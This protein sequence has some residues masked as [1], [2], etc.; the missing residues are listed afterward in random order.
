MPRPPEV[1]GSSA[2][3][4]VAWKPGRDR[5]LCLAGGAAL[6]V[7]AGAVYGFGAIAESMRDHLL[8]SS[9]QQ[10]ALALCGNVG[11]WVGSFTGG[12]VADTKGP[13]TAMLGGALFFGV[14][15]GG[16]WLVLRSGATTASGGDNVAY[17]AAVL[18]LV[19]GLGS[20]WV[21]NATIFTNSANFG[22]AA[23]AK[24]IGL[25]ATLFGAS[26]TI[27]STVLNGCVGGKPQ[28][29]AA[30]PSAALSLQA[31]ALYATDED[32]ELLSAADGS[33]AG[34]PGAGYTCLGG[35][36][37]GGIVSYFF[38]LAVAL[39]L[40]TTVGAFASFRITNG[41]ERAEAD[42]SEGEEPV[43][44]RLNISSGGVLVLL[45]FVGVTS[46]LVVGK[47]G[48]EVAVYIRKYTS[49]PHHTR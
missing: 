9:H 11:L 38:L 28:H 29:A 3:S 43:S 18:W 8:L 25:L 1:L 48:Q 7:C 39:P 20:G 24:V 49:N 6:I 37:N 10:G 13:R 19:S 14:G 12:I 26:S 27:W 23:R 2:P 30:A 22:P 40:I 47:D 46:G 5:W 15:Y 33:D 41:T 21:Y 32:D 16:M 4:T 45:V 35:W 44:Q 17:L 34:A 31:L 42:R 36:V